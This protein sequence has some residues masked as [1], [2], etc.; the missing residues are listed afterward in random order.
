MTHQL[1][2]EAD[3]AYDEQARVYVFGD[4]TTS[5]KARDHMEDQQDLRE[6]FRKALV[7]ALPTGAHV[8]NE[9]AFL[10]NF[11]F[12]VT[13]DDPKIFDTH[14]KDALEKK[15]P[16]T[17]Y[18]H[19]RGQGLWMVP[20]QEIAPNKGAITCI[21]LGLVLIGILVLALLLAAMYDQLYFVLR[22]Y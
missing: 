21:D 14:Y 18:M 20:Y 22:M 5:R 9:R 4:V 1:A 10:E 8:A 6:T 3:L 11:C 19:G 12:A 2:S 16:G 13:Y 17:K 15:F 7:D